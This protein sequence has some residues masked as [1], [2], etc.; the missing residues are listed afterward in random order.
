MSREKRNNSQATQHVG[1]VVSENTLKYGLI[2]TI[3]EESCQE[4]TLLST[5]FFKIR[6]SYNGAL[7]QINIKYLALS[8]F[9]WVNLSY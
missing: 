8:H 7:I 3:N 5:I 2:L 4:Q 9:K 6:S 1:C